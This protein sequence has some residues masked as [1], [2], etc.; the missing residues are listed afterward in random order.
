MAA[1]SVMINLELPHMNI[2][3]KMDQLKK[4][5]RSQLDGFLDPDPHYLLGSME[6]CSVWNERYKNLTEAIGQILVDYSLV[7]FHTLN[8]KNDENIGD[9]LVTV[10]NVIQFGED[11][12]VK[13]HDFEYPDDENNDF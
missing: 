2:I 4:F 7:R 13:T 1:L 6:S 11:A 10:D 5:Q 3:T 9:I 12:D 8:I